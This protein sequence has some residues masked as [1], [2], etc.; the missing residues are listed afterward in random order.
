[1]LDRD[2]ILQARAL[3]TESVEVPEWGGTVNVRALTAAE[4]DDY[5]SSMIVG[6]G[7]NREVSMANAR[8]RLCVR[9]IVD[10]EGKRLFSDDDSGDLG[11]QSA[12]TLDRVYEV[13]ARLNGQ[14]DEDIEGLAKN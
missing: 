2:A 6:K 11:K 1:M 9:C 7:K 10:T 12:L 13:A 3:P 14:T 4:K 5:E 8:A